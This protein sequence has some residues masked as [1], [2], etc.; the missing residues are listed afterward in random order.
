MTMTI[1]T[2]RFFGAALAAAVVGG[3]LVACTS[4]T[5]SPSTSTAP[6]AQTL[7]TQ[8]AP[9][10][11]A[12]A[13]SGAAA[14]TQGAPTAQALATQ[15]APTVQSLATQSA[16]TVQSLA[17]QSAPTVQAL[18]TQVAP[19]AA[20]A[21]ASAPV[22]I[23]GVQSTSTDASISLQNTSSSNADLGG[24]QLKVGTSTVTLPAGLTVPAGQT[25]TLHTASGTSTATEVYLGS[26]A[27]SITPLLKPGAQVVLQ[28]PSGAPTTAFTIPSA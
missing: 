19:V 13:T 17:T 2:P 14:A 11:Q 15:A 20:T 7:A 10:V 18:A 28:N 24:W 8:A 5:P 4:S 27:S 25:V 16:P 23:L 6:T 22:R 12:L 3:A 26:T 9:T 1:T 21:S